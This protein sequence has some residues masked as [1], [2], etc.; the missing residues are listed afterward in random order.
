MAERTARCTSTH[1]FSAVEGY[2]AAESSSFMTVS[3]TAHINLLNNALARHE[4]IE[5][6]EAVRCRRKNCC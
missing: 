4:L 3:A 1:L 6:R 2:V 5:R